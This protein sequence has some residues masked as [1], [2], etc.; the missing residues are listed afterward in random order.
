MDEQGKQPLEIGINEAVFELSR[1]DAARLLFMAV[2]DY[3]QNSQLEAPDE[4]SDLIRGALKGIFATIGN[5][6]LFAIYGQNAPRL[7]RKQDRLP[8]MWKAMTDW[9]I[10][11]MAKHTIELQA[12]EITE[13]RYRIIG[14]VADSV[15][16]E[17]A[18]VDT[19]QETAE[20]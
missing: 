16:T 18:R 3:L 20:V 15:Y 10:L 5:K 6:L 2:P 17:P 8:V 19:E 9:I 1:A 4:V 7:E 12:V 11:T 13:G 14:V